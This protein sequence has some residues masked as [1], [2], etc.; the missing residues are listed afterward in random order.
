MTSNTDI[1]IGLFIYIIGI[2][3]GGECFGLKLH[4]A[5]R[6]TYMDVIRHCTAGEQ[7]GY[8]VSI[9]SMYYVFG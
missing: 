7:L 3:G 6:N 5:L 1:K 4:C 9:T 8:I 2:L